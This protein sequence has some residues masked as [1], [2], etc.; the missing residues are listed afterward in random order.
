MANFGSAKALGRTFRE[1]MYESSKKS[2]GK[3]RRGR[4]G[5]LTSTRLR[6][7]FGLLRAGKIKG[8]K[9]SSR[10][11]KFRKGMKK[12]R[13]EIGTKA[14]R[15]E[16]AAQLRKNRRSPAMV[17]RPSTVARMAQRIAPKGR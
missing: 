6:R 10:Y 2:K 12:R 5:K 1:G 3:K 9:F 16:A 17:I 14:F 4:G 11:S 15:A 13:K 8:K 7:F